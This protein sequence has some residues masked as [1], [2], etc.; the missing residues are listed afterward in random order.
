M[1]M[2]MNSIM[3]FVSSLAMLLPIVLIISL[4]LSSYR[5][6]PAL[7]V[8][9]TSALIY[10]LLTQHYITLNA[11]QTRFVG[12]TNNLL[13]IPL[14]LFFLTY[15]SASR[16]FSKRLKLVILAFLVFE[17]AVVLISGYNVNAITITLGPGLVLVLAVSLYFFIRQAKMAIIHRKATGKALMISAILFGYG[18]FSFIYL[19]YYVFKA[20]L[21]ESGRVREQY[22]QDTFLIY[23]L[24][25]TISA[26]LLCVGIIIERK[27]IQK[28]N[29]L[30][31]TRKELSTI[32]TETKRAVP[33]RTAMLDF[34][35]DQ[36]N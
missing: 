30:K 17:L 15:F 29:E 12:I 22:K 24:S 23:F 19:M 26:L 16:E 11:E 10:N 36:W 9:Y 33:Y 28:L 25:T 27:R 8:Y 5:S 18:C 14:M 20:H 2:T 3:G 21:D 35:K 1:N 6:F 31:Q 34:D 4:R 32:Y 13:D 7:L